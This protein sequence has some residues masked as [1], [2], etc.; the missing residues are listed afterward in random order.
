MYSAKFIIAKMDSVNFGFLAFAS[1]YVYVRICLRSQKCMQ[2]ETFLKHKQTIIFLM[3]HVLNQSIYGI[4][5]Y[6]LYCYKT[7]RY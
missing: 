1:G 7:K 4:A 6:R 5:P 2:S 3:N